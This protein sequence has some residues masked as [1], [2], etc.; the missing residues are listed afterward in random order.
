MNGILIFIILLIG[1]FLIF[2]MHKQAHTDS[3]ENIRIKD[4]KYPRKEGDL[5]FFF[6]SDIHKR[7]IQDTTL[8]QI[9]HVQFTVIGGDLC[10]KGVSLQRVEGNVK[11]LKQLGAPIYFIW[12]N[13][14]VE[15]SEQDLIATLE[16]NDVHILT[17]TSVTFELKNGKQVTLI[18]LDC[19]TVRDV[20]V[21]AGFKH[22]NGDYIILAIHDP[23]TF[24]LLNEKEQKRVNLVVSGHT[25]GGQIR[26]LGWGLYP[27]GGL[28]KRALTHFFISEGYG[29]TKLPLRLGTKAECHRITI[30]SD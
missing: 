15:V 12:G 2:H 5:S 3:F 13:N 19:D 4:A 28:S 21:E 23:K 18:G 20:D 6:I 14:D 9:G 10:E 16:R 25:H 11:K 27:R 1:I 26:I 24:E 17:N 30:T 7:I 22:A 29:T 8:Q